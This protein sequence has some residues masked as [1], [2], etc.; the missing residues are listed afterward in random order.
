M[1]LEFC[2]LRC[3]WNVK[4][5]LLSLDGDTK[6]KKSILLHQSPIREASEII[7]MNIVT[8]CYYHIDEQ[9][10]DHDPRLHPSESK[11]WCYEKI[12]RAFKR[13]LLLSSFI[14]VSMYGKVYRVNYIFIIIFYNK[15]ST[16]WS[17][18]L[19]SSIEFL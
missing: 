11:I 9:C 2:L 12:S 8:H 10:W 4:V 7:I 18:S 19:T 14:N 6:L 1:N 13:G 17:S 15:L 3:Y 16:E 5:L